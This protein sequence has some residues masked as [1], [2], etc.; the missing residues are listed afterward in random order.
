MNIEACNRNSIGLIAENWHEIEDAIERPLIYISEDLPTYSCILA[1]NQHLTLN[2]NEV[3]IIPLYC[4]KVQLHEL[5]LHIAT[6][7]LIPLHAEQNL[8]GAGPQEKLRH[9]LVV[10]YLYERFSST[11]MISREHY[12]SLL[13]YQLYSSWI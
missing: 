11:L 10:D 1:H 9:T 13:S 5:I 4:W 2:F 12:I 7:S 8:G 3:K 6:Y